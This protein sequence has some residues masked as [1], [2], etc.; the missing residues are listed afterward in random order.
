MPKRPYV[1]TREFYYIASLYLAICIL[2]SVLLLF[3]IPGLSCADDNTSSPQISGLTVA[4][5]KRY[6]LAYFSLKN[7]YTDEILA[8]MQSG[9]PIKYTYEIE[10]SEP[11]F[12]M[13]KTIF[14]SYVS[15]TLSYDALRQE[16]IMMLG[17]NN[18]RAIS[19]RTKAEVWPVIF[20]M[21]GVPL[22]PVSR[23]QRG[24]T[25]RLQ[26]RARVEK[27]ESHIPFPGLMDVFSPWG[28]ETKWYEIYFT[29]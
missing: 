27:A 26:V 9:I 6:L 1:I 14:H 3:S 16:Y 20:E 21:N 8:A 15:R 5:S 24:T 4:N 13:D 25:Y 22:V 23:L 2:G 19:V 12:L 10:I 29:Y 18:P 17:P 28:F 11:R 7:G